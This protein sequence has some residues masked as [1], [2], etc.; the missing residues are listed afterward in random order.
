MNYNQNNQ[1][2][3]NTEQN[4][5]SCMFYCPNISSCQRMPPTVQVFVTDDG[6]EVVKSYFPRVNASWCWC[7]EYKPIRNKN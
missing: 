6:K 3:Q 4:C 1:N 7:G 5:L 2:T